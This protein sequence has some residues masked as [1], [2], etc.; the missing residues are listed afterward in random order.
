LAYGNQTKAIYDAFDNIGNKENDRD[1]INENSGI[2]KPGHVF[3]HKTIIRN[4]EP[5]TLVIAI[6]RGTDFGTANF[7]ADVGTDLLHMIIGTIPTN[8]AFAAQHLDKYLSDN[9]IIL[10]RRFFLV[11]GHSLGGGMANCVANTLSNSVPKS[12]VFAF[13]FASP[14]ALLLKVNRHG[15]FSNFVSETDLFQHLLWVTKNISLYLIKSTP[16]NLQQQIQEQWN[17][18]LLKWIHLQKI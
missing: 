7:W 15:N 8:A 12:N 18:P 4:G 10:K 6:F 14:K 5:K 9:K 17:T 1:F 16:L 2:W 13:T 3:G 11:T